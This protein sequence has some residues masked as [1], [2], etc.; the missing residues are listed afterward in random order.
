MIELEKVSKTYNSDGVMVQELKSVNLKIED[1]EYVAVMGRSGSGKSTLLHII[2]AMDSITSG[3]YLYNGVEINTLERKEFENFRK[4][5]AS[6]IF[7]N[8][9]LVKY[10]I[11]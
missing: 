2:G 7:R 3:R 9:F 1:G 10:H 8:Y 6:F 5:H 11:I 4:E